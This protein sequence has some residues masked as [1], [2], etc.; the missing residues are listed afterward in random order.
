MPTADL[1]SLVSTKCRR[2]A[3]WVPG[4]PSE[5]SLGGQGGGWGPNLAARGRPLEMGMIPTP[6]C[7]KVAMGP[8]ARFARSINGTEYHNILTADLARGRKPRSQLYIATVM[9]DVPLTRASL[10]PRG[11]AAR[12]QGRGGTRGSESKS[13]RGPGAGR[14]DPLARP[15]PWPP[16]VSDPST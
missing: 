15:A 2:A 5:M 10:A 12:A 6:N 1:M 16:R 13:R 7:E 4:G 14:G 3:R 9:G 8:G 11:P